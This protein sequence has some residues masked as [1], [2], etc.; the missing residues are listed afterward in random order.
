MA[1]N[2]GI[3]SQELQLPLEQVEEYVEFNNNILSARLVL[4]RTRE[5]LIKFTPQYIIEE[6]EK[7]LK[8]DI[9]LEYEIKALHTLKELLGDF[10][11]TNQLTKIKIEEFIRFSHY[12]FEASIERASWVKDKVI[13]NLFEKEYQKYTSTI[14]FILNQNIIL[15]KKIKDINPKNEEEMMQEVKRIIRMGP[16]IQINIL[17]TY[18]LIKEKNE[19]EEIAE[20]LFNETLECIRKFSSINEI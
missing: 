15:L 7:L 13:N 2:N 18:I 3:L 19:Q 8:L 4:E 6:I 5:V 12:A 10:K 9:W 11:K 20:G 14:L 17:S 16:K 1:G